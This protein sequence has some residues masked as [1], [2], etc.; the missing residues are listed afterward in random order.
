MIIG[1]YSERLGLGLSNKNRYGK[2]NLIVAYK[3]TSEPEHLFRLAMQ[4]NSLP[5]WLSAD[6]Q[7]LS[8]DMILDLNDHGRLEVTDVDDIGWIRF[9]R[10]L[11]RQ[12]SVIQLSFKPGKG[13]NPCIVHIMESGI[14]DP[15]KVPVFRAFWTSIA[16][17]ILALE[18]PQT[19]KS[20]RR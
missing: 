13:P 1:N 20:C 19:L 16:G 17:K 10:S 7:T 6:G 12:V 14:F 2:Y 15:D 11:K 5:A 4:S 3:S 8:P 18:S 9:E